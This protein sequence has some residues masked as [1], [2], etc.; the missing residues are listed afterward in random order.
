MK[1]NNFSLKMDNKNRP[2]T[3][4]EKNNIKLLFYEKVNIFNKKNICTNDYVLYGLDMTQFFCIVATKE[5]LQF[6]LKWDD[7]TKHCLHTCVVLHI[8]KWGLI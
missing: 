8:I 6:V 7:S 3:A 2:M 1:S 5:L 4:T